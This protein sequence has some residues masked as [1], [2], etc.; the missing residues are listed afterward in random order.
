[1]SDAEWQD[2][3]SLSKVIIVVKLAYCGITERIRNNR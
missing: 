3:G 2:K 1:M